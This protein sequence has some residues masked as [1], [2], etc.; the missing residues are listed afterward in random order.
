MTE[1]GENKLDTS[2]GKEPLYS[3]WERIMPENFSLLS[4]TMKIKGEF[5]KIESSGENHYLWFIRDNGD[6]DLFKMKGGQISRRARSARS[7]IQRLRKELLTTSGQKRI[8]SLKAQVEAEQMKF[9]WPQML[10]AYFRGEDVGRFFTIRRKKSNGA[11]DL[12]VRYAPKHKIVKSEV[13]K[14]LQS[15]RAERPE[16]TLDESKQVFANLTG[17]SYSNVNRLYHYRAKK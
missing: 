8:R 16:T 14:L 12:S 10:V 5:L 1:S 3:R 17:D 2:V 6:V 13:D 9:I 4:V 15:L 11:E 7:R